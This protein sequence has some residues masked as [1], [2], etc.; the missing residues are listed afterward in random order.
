[1]SESRV[2]RSRREQR[3]AKVKAQEW[4]AAREQ[5]RE[6]IGNR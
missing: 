1:M 4:I 5:R 3:R 6:M 2:K